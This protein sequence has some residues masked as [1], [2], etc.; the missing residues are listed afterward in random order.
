MDHFGWTHIV[1]ENDLQTPTSRL[2]NETTYTR[3]RRP[4]GCV[5]SACLQLGFLPHNVFP[6]FTDRG[7]PDLARRPSAA[8]AAGPPRRE[9]VSGTRRKKLKFVEVPSVCQGTGL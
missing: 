3:L 1:N 7:W 2:A 6:R 8:G 4:R 5:D 9:W